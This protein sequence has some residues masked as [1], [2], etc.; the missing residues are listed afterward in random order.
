MKHKK[1]YL[2]A[3][4]S[5]LF[6][7]NAIVVDADVISDPNDPQE[8]E[9][10]FI[11]QQQ[12]SMKYLF[13]NLEPQGT[14]PGV[15]IASPQK[16]GP[17][18][19]YHWVR[20][21]ALVMDIVVEFARKTRYPESQAHALA[22]L[23][24]YAA[25]SRRNQL[26]PNRSGEGSIDDL[27]GLGEPK[28]HVDGKAFDGDW[29]R[30]Q[31]DG[32]ALRA[33]TMIKYANFLLS[34]GNQSYVREF[35]YDGM[36][37]SNSLIKADLEY[38]SHYWRY[39]TFDL[40]E[41]VAGDQFYTRMVQRKALIDGAR[42]AED[43]KDV[44]AAK[45]YRGQAQAIANDLQKHW[46]HERGRVHATIHTVGGYTAKP[47]GLDVSVLLG[48]LHGDNGDG[49]FGPT[50]ER[51]LAT[52]YQLKTAFKSIY[53]VNQL[54]DVPGTAIGR[55]PEDVYDGSGTPNKGN[56]WFL[57]TMAFA[58]L[59]YKAETDF[60]NQSSIKITTYNRPFFADL[61]PDES[62]EVGNIYTRDEEMF[63]KILMAMRAEAD[64]YLKR[65][66]YH[67]DRKNGEMS[68]QFRR[69]NGLMT[70]AANLTWNYAAFLTAAWAR[71]KSQDYLNR[72]RELG[73]R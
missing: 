66:A 61:L 49:F 62:L 31:S 71:P 64:S 23:H 14:A 27:R 12:R 72:L 18:Y 53:G 28:F 67:S 5:I 47:S 35:L 25:F 40:W 36:L 65:V 43:L 19:F 20:D 45:W 52:A 15:V 11:E 34:K 50:D 54:E 8:F 58:E 44:E 69:D 24:N 41:E 22:L 26:T 63:Q 46:D 37:P 68:E 30:P 9:K 4:L 33:I 1:V 39:K 59:L 13:R 57:A 7:F 2:S 55:Y 17:D 3:L 73:I 51:I 70:S 16:S 38:I 48:V 10:W 21:A 60:K 6:L 42:F 29:G 56:P 32:P